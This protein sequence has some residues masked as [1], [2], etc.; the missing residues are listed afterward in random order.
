[1][2]GSAGHPVTATIASRDK[3]A[4]TPTCSSAPGV[5][6][7]VTISNNRGRVR[8]FRDVAN[9]TMDLNDIEVLNT[10]LR[11]GTDTTTVGNLAGTD[12]DHVLNRLGNNPG[13][14][15]RIVAN[16]TRRI[17]HVDVMARTTPDGTVAHV[18][19]LPAVIELQGAGIEDQLEVRTGSGADRINSSI[20]ANALT[21]TADGGSGDDQMLGGDADEMFI[22]GTGD[23]VID[24]NRGNDLARLGEG[25]LDLFIWDPGDG[26][27][28]VDGAAGT[29]VLVFRGLRRLSGS[30][31]PARV[32]ASR[33]SPA[34]SATS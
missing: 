23:D 21:F 18:L 22:G 15:G 8:F 25:E 7:N 10:D 4:T 2:T 24:G 11:T 20:P 13:S 16:G 31:S 27:D 6:E 14:Q 19:G 3:R 1:M 30:R 32:G 28:R 12:V 33:G 34:T 9:V 26:S 17:D 5:D 29:D